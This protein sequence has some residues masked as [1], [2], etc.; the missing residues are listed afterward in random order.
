MTQITID[1]ISDVFIL[2]SLFKFLRLV[3]YKTKQEN[4][5]RIKDKIKKHTT[6]FSTQNNNNGEPA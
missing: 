3:M 6:G 1:A 2:R 5:N 4:R